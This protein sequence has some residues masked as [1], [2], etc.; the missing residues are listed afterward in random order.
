[1]P[2]GTEAG[3]NVN[4]VA[5]RSMVRASDADREHVAERLR[6][7]ASEGRLLAEELEQRL[8]AALRART[9]GELD[10][11]VLDLP[12]Q[13]AVVPR[14]R[15]LTFLRPLAIAF[16]VVILLAA[17]LAALALV[18]TGTIVLGGAWMFIAIC[19]FGW[20][21]GYHRGR[22][23]RRTRWQSPAGYIRWQ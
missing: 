21:R 15:A 23:G 4:G 17:L 7:A 1:M 19:A 16:A 9:Y 11:L 18:V 2:P 10:E 5:R 6:Q 14:S 13:R 20:R 3:A 12:S 22:Y 8:A